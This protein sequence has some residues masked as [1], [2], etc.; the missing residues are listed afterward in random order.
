M[1]NLTS[2]VLILA[3][4][5]LAACTQP[6]AGSLSAPHGPP[7]DSGDKDGGGAA[8]VRCS[9]GIAEHCGQV[10]ILPARAGA[11]KLPQIII[12]TSIG[13]LRRTAYGSR[14]NSIRRTSISVP[15]PAA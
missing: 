5:L 7:Y 14:T 2:T 15:A 12:A 13:D 9:G 1:R 3:V 10:G 8:A 11:D 6:M 4:L